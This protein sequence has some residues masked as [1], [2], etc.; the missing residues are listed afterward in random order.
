MPVINTKHHIDRKAREILDQLAVDLADDTLLT[1]LQCANWLGVSTQFLELG[2]IRNYGPPAVSIAPRV[3][4]YRKN[5]VLRWLIERERA[6]AKA[7]REK[8]EA[9]S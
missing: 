7:Q 4:R 3:I 2:R 9:S 6:Y 1:T 8:S 5:S